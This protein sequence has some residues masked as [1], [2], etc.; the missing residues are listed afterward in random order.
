MMSGQNLVDL[1]ELGRSQRS[2]TNSMEMPPQTSPSAFSA[3]LA[4]LRGSNLE[5]EKSPPG[6]QGK[7]ACTAKFVC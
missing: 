4:S 5:E 2:C 6:R 7:R 3:F 1:R